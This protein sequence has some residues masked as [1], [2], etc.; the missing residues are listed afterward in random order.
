M[1]HTYAI[2]KVS[3]PTYNEVARRMQ[4]AGHNNVFHEGKGKHPVIDMHGI[5]LEPDVEIK[6][7]EASFFAGSVLSSRTKQG[8]VQMQLND[9]VVQLDLDKAREVIQMLQTA[10][11]AAISDQLF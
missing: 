4:Q 9:A 6:P 5:A 3:P 2:L 8:L 1:T 11:E 10:V 7:G